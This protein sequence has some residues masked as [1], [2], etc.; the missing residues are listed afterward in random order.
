M[1]SEITQKPPGRR[2]T[3]YAVLAVLAV[4]LTWLVI[5]AAGMPGNSRSGDGFIEQVVGDA[6]ARATVTLPLALK[7]GDPQHEATH[8]FQAVSSVPGI[9]AARLMLAEKTLVVTYDP[10][11]LPESGVRGAL[12]ASG[13][14]AEEGSAR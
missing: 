2:T 9:R 14:L 8:V 7:E 4:V 6:E 10:R 12:Q 1:G 13:Y 3:R 11:R 5:S